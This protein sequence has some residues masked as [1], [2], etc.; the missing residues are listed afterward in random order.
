MRLLK[1]RVYIPNYT[2]T[3]LCTFWYSPLHEKQIHQSSHVTASLVKT[4]GAEGWHVYTACTSSANR[5]VEPYAGALQ[6][7]PDYRIVAE[8]T[9][10]DV[11]TIYPSPNPKYL[12]HSV[13]HPISSEMF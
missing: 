10:D 11:L 8:G 6:T 1:R 12:K 3:D 13:K 5:N 9:I 7:Y 4:D 2:T